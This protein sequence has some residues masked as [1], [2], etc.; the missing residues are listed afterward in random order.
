MTIKEDY[1]NRKEGNECIISG[2]L[3]GHS[4]FLSDLDEFIFDLQH[5]EEVTNMQFHC[6]SSFPGENYLQNI[7]YYFPKIQETVLKLCQR[8]IIKVSQIDYSVSFGKFLSQLKSIRNF[9]FIETN[10][11]ESQIKDIFL[12]ISVF[13]ALN[14]FS[15]SDNQAGKNIRNDSRDKIG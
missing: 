7:F 9:Q 6:W 8:L 4:T 12:N 13:G 2:Y 11:T 10:F 14:K 1:E 3:K 15:V 5:N